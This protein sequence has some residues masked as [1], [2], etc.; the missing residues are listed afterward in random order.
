[1][2]LTEDFFDLIQDMVVEGWIFESIQRY[3]PTVLTGTTPK[4]VKFT[5]SVSGNQWTLQYRNRNSSGPVPADW[6][7]GSRVKQLLRTSATQAGE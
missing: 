3:S 7:T 4:G 2:L 5:F 1:M 6:E